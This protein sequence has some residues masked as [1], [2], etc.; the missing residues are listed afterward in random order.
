MICEEATTTTTVTMTGQESFLDR[1]FPK[2]KISTLT[3]GRRSNRHTEHCLGDEEEEEEEEKSFSSSSAAPHWL[4][5]QVC[6]QP[7]GWQAAK[8]TG[9]GGQLI[10]RHRRWREGG[11]EEEEEEPEEEE[12]EEPE[13]EKL[14]RRERGKGGYHGNSRDDTAAASEDAGTHRLT[15]G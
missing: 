15:S 9:R 5:V 12:E 14:S 1:W 13:E 4:K 10:D 2:G 8:K 6:R 3:S 7:I 11:E